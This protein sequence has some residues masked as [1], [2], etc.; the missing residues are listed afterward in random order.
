MIFLRQSGRFFNSEA[1]SDLKKSTCISDRAVVS[2]FLLVTG[3]VET[4]NDDDCGLEIYSRR[5]GKRK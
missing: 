2:Y 4:D 5:K 3:R 1:C